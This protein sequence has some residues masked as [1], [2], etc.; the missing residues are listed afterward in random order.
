MRDGLIERLLW[1]V[2]LYSNAASELEAMSAFKTKDLGTACT[3]VSA[4]LDALSTFEDEFKHKG[5]TSPLT[6]DN[7]CYLQPVY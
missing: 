3:K 4:T 2:D 6:K 5:E 7:D 1:W